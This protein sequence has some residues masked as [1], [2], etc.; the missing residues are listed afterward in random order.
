M[1]EASGR[2]PSGTAYHETNA[3]IEGYQ[4]GSL[5]LPAT[6]DNSQSQQGIVVASAI[7]EFEAGM[8][9]AYMPYHGEVIQLKGKEYLCIPDRELVAW[10]DADKSG[11]D[12]ICPRK[13]TLLIQP[14]WQPEKIG[15]IIL[16]E[17][18][19]LQDPVKI[20]TVLK[21]GAF[22][23]T[24]VGTRVVFPPDKGFEIGLLDVG[25]NLY[26]LNEQHLQAYLSNA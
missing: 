20:G 17:Y 4:L 24:E 21:Q 15:S 12:R 18:S 1:Y 26:L 19:G 14:E 16:P 13:G 3:K 5:V 9:A 7:D 23:V 25:E 11:F 8:L 10:L 2:I 6:G 22:T